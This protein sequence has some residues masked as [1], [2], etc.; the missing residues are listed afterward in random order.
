[1]ASNY[2]TLNP[3]YPTGKFSPLTVKG[4][5]RELIEG[6]EKKLTEKINQLNGYKAKREEKIARGKDL[7]EDD[8]K[9][10][11]RLEQIV[12]DLRATI[13]Q[14]KDMFNIR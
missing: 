11:K 4:K 9:V 12:T 13:K 8:L 14:Q 5:K 1:M 2:A 6:F 7:S 10:M 3:E